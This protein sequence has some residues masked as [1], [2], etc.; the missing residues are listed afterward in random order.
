MSSIKKL[1]PDIIGIIVDYISD[2]KLINTI[3]NLSKKLKE[4]YNYMLVRYTGFVY[5]NDIKCISNYVYDL[6]LSFRCAYLDDNLLKFILT[7]CPNVKKLNISGC[8]K[9]TDK[10]FENL[11]ETHTLYMSGCDQ[12]TIT[13]KAFEQLKG[14]HVLYM[15]DCYQNTITDKSFK[16]LKGIHTLY[17]SGCKQDTITDKAFEN[18]K[19]IHTLDMFG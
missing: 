10:A 18:L 6:D 2:T 13:D 1:C 17:M 11:K 8:L 15:I 16:H 9:I 19:G 7:K 3:I 4:R 12:N 5:H 14:I